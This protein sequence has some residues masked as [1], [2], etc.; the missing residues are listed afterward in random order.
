QEKTFSENQDGLVPLLA[1]LVQVLAGLGDHL[2]ARELIERIRSIRSHS[3]SPDPIAQAFDLVSLSDSHRL[4]GDLAR[5]GDLARQA[6]DMARGHLK[7]G[8]PGLVGYLTHFGRTCQ[9]QQA[10]SA[11]RRHFH[12]AMALVRKTGGDRHPLVPGLRAD[13]A[14]LEVSR[15]KSRRAT[16]LYTQ[17]AELLQA[18][19]G[20]DHPDHATARRVLGQHLQTLGEY[21]G[22]EEALRRHLNIVLR[23]YGTEHPAA[24]LAY[25]ALSELQ[26]QRGDLAGA[27]ASCRQ[28]LDLVRLAE[29]PLDA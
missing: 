4:L 14:S 1:D 25:Q 11:A 29:V 27:K 21:A 17:A 9:A 20:E 2:A 3:T 16:P 10:F 28:A 8:D 22:A 26:R 19:L 18:V 23:S 7:Q 15:G 12:E 5:A 24:A 13:L 6:L